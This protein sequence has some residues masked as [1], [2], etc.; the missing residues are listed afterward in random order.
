MAKLKITR[1][2]NI[3]HYDVIYECGCI[4][5]AIRGTFNVIACKEGHNYKEGLLK[6]P[7]RCW[8]LYSDARWCD[9]HYN[10]QKEAKL[11]SEI[12]DAKNKVAYLESKL[13]VLRG[14]RN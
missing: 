9:E 1:T 4:R 14:R 13:Q 3:E 11:C 2:H 7:C 8:D 6:L 10:L 5:D 12:C